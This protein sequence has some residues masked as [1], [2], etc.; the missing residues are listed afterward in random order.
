MKRKKKHLLSPNY[1][2]RSRQVGDYV[3]QLASFDPTSTGSSTRYF[4]MKVRRWIILDSNTYRLNFNKFLYLVHH[5]IISQD[6]FMLTIDENEI[7][8]TVDICKSLLALESRNTCKIC[9]LQNRY[10]MF[11]INITFFHSNQKKFI[12]HNFSN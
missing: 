3:S 7:V 2:K 1:D 11:P 4:L 12:N 6:K 9:V 5:S 8:L 10:P